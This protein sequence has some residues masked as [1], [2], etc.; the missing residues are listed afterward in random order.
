MIELTP[1]VLAGILLAIGMLLL[2]IV[3]LV[4]LSVMVVTYILRA[5]AHL[6]GEWPVFG[7][8]GGWHEP[9]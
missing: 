9:H 5:L 2:A 4:V 8:V 7:G 6:D 3:G 1:G